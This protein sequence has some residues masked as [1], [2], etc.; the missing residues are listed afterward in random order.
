MQNGPKDPAREFEVLTLIST[1][2]SL[3]VVYYAHIE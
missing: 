3:S 2:V 1:L